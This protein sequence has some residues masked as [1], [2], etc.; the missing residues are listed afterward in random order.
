MASETYGDFWDSLIQNER[1]Q[2]GDEVAALAE[3]IARNATASVRQERNALRAG[4]QASK[5]FA[6]YVKDAELELAPQNERNTEFSFKVHLRALA[7]QDADALGQ[8]MKSMKFMGV[9]PKNEPVILK[10]DEVQKGNYPTIGPNPAS[11]RLALPIPPKY[12]DEQAQA[13]RQLMSLSQ[14]ERRKILA[15][16]SKSLR[17]K[18]LERSGAR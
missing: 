1:E 18:L 15:D 11:E 6:D 12:T 5:P 16:E 14:V 3:N 2:Y 10:L 9:S 4:V 13:A 8:K 7:R 17:Q